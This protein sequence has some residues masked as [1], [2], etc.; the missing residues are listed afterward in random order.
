MFAR[1]KL[2]IIKVSS[3][4]WKSTSCSK[5]NQPEVA[6]RSVSTFTVDLYLIDASTP[7]FRSKKKKPSSAIK[8]YYWDNKFRFHWRQPP[9]LV[10][11]PRHE[12]T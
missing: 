6:A 3:D 12:R 4:T 5:A 7:N 10:N 11:G 1:L 9:R 8:Y 2:R